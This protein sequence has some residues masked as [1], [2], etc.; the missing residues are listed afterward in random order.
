MPRKFPAP[1]RSTSLK[2][3][4]NLT[5]KVYPTEKGWT[6][7]WKTPRMPV[8]SFVG[9]YFR[10]KAEATSAARAFG[11]AFSQLR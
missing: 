5:A 8:S 9:R 7:S 1:R 2:V 4:G 10:T 3:R 6:F 11:K